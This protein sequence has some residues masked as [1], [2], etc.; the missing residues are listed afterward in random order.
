VAAEEECVLVEG[1]H[2]TLVHTRSDWLGDRQ[3]WVLPLEGSVRSGSAVA[4]PGE[5]LL[6]DPGDALECS[7]GEMLIGALS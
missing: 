6:L 4:G 2:F 7:G 1:P 5:C 3:R